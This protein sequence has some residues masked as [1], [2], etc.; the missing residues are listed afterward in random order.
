MSDRAASA[1]SYAGGAASVV[2][3]LTLTEIGITI[4]IV[5]AV[6]TFVLNV[7]YHYRKDKR[8]REAHELRLEQI[9]R[10]PERR[11]GPRPPI[12]CAEDP[13]PDCPYENMQQ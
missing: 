7:V 13:P 6:L 2:S 4:G 10:N 8:E 9:R 5:T 3:A 11:K 1:T 12:G